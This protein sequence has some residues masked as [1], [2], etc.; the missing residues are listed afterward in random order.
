MNPENSTLPQGLSISCNVEGATMYAEIGTTKG[1]QNLMSTVEDLLSS[2]DLS[3][4]V[5]GTVETAR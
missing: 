4:R 3:L 5:R 2:I 1:V